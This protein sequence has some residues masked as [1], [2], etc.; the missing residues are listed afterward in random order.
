MARL[1]G[2]SPVIVDCP[3]SQDFMLTPQ[4][5]EAALKPSSRLL[6]LCSPSNP[7]GMG[8]P[9]EAWYIIDHVFWRVL[10]ASVLLSIESPSCA[11]VL[12]LSLCSHVPD[13]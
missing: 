2:A 5:L 11:P 4:Q 7:S 10:G 3:Q 8:L 13:F 6:I 1:A 12:V 9:W